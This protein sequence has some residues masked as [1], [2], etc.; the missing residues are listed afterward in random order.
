MFINTSPSYYYT[1]YAT[2][3]Y[4]YLFFNVVIVLWFMPE[5]ERWTSVFF[6]NIL[7]KLC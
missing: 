4:E 7:R 5:T 3:Q 1:M 6:K 2:L